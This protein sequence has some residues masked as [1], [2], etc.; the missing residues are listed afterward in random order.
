MLQ[1][2]DHFKLERD[3]IAERLDAE[4]RMNEKMMNAFKDNCESSDERS[5]KK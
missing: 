2:I 3:D 5:S 4:K 1:E